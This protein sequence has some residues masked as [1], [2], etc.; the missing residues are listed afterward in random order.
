VLPVRDDRPFFLQT[1]FS[2]PHEPFLCTQEYWDRYDHEAIQIPE[3][4]DNLD[5]TY[6]TMDRSLN[7]YH[8]CGEVDLKNPESLRNLHHSYLALISYIDDKVGQL[9]D[10]LERTGLADDTIVIF[11][12]DHGDMLGHRGMVQKRHFYDQSSR[13]PLIFRFP[14]SFPFG[15]A[16]HVCD[17][18]VSIVD[19]CPTIAALAGAESLLPMDGRSLLPQLRGESDPDRAVFC[20]NHVSG[21]ATCC[22]MVRRGRHK[23]TYIHETGETRLFDMVADPRE[24]NNLSG[25][26]EW[27]ATERE[28]KDLIFQAFDVERIDREIDLSVQRRMLIRNSFAVTGPPRWSHQPYFNAEEQYWRKD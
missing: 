7:N 3:Y 21:V 27:A 28:L 15:K 6:T 12:S 5:Q 8:G 26:P 16:G 25:A 9:L 11:T 14:N 18:P 4:P 19:L 24:W 20:E 23:F 10:C 13:I 17:D 22:F 2:Y 1:S